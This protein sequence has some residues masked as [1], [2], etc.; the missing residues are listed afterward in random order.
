MTKLSFGL[1]SFL[2]LSAQ[3]SLLM[4]DTIETE[5]WQIEADKVLRFD[6][7]SSI[8][9]EGNVVLVK[10]RKLPAAQKKAK[11]S[12]T[13]WSNLLEE[14]PEIDNEEI[15]QELTTEAEPR[16]ETAV[17]V[18]ADWIAYDVEHNKIKARGNVSIVD[19]KNKLLAESGTLN[20]NNETGSFTKATI[21]RDKLDLHLEGET[22]TKTGA[23]TYNIIDGWVVTCKVSE[24]ETPPWSFAAA[25][26]EVTQG[27]YATLTHAT[28]RIKDVPVFYSP[29][30]M[31]P[32]G[33]TR[34]TGVLFP[35]VSTSKYGG[36]GV[37]LPLF[38][39]LSDSSDMT[40][41]TEYYSNR[42]FMPGLEL[43]Y[44]LG[45]QKK[46]GFVASYLKD[47]LSDPSETEYYN[48]TGYTHTNDDRYWVRGKLD[49]D[50]D[51]GIVTRTD[52][53]IVSDRDYL[54]EFNSGSTGFRNSQS[55]FLHAFGRG[56]QNKTN[57]QRQNTFKVLKSWDGMAL[58]GVFLGIND[59]RQDT[60]SPTPLWKLPSLDF[61]GSR[62]LGF[63]DL[64]I[65][66]DA[67][68]VNY[69]REDGVGGHR[70]DIYPRLSMPLPL[71]PYFESRAEAGVR[72]TLYSVQTFGDGTW[73][74]SSSPN[75]LLGEFHTEIGST[76]LRDFGVAI[77]DMDGITHNFRPYV[78]YDFLSDT[79]QDDLPSFDAVDRKS[80]LNKV[81]YGI[82]NFFNLFGTSSGKDTSKEYGELKIKQSYD[83]RS[84]AS[85]EPLSP[86]N[87]K[88]Q[89]TPLKQLSAAKLIYK[90]DLSVYGKGSSHTVEAFYNN[91][92][93]DSFNLDYRYDDLNGAD[94]Q[95]INFA[96]R[97]QLWDTIFAAY[98]IKHSIS[99]SQIIEQNISLMYRP[100]CWSIELQS[101]YT[102]AD[103]TFFVLFNLANIGSPLGLK[104]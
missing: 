83:I 104:L 80:D 78:Q 34:Q 30:L 11:D 19:G 38:I 2:I 58:E 74:K 42:G 22:I 26:T 36:F 85:N 43:R 90:T 96:A 68:Y 64:N 62:I 15:T 65:D 10:I 28:F 95:Q 87:V 59:V 79:D 16:I 8:V 75:R 54:T 69:Y 49:H 39:N 84:I 57:D 71:G 89:L 14:E 35:E 27:E 45:N 55:R 3:T 102:P 88:L 100:A 98:D 4:A 72:E 66:W 7:P 56:F 70:F 47:D 50:F 32:V 40:L 6:N 92:R 60:S 33:N 13:E 1:A 21:L 17:T 94:T 81:T 63:G 61:T 48:D 20:L 25:E 9:A 24:G 53:D 77:N 67:D 103:T 5:E 93:G 91:S 76:L 18:S 23:N 97:A 46:G 73:D 31:V 82:D 12:G 99:S 52:L 41:Y 86:V 37:N 51:N 101:K 44:A 29:W